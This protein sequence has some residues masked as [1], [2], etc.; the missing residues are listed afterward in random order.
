MPAAGLPGVG[1]AVLS[2]RLRQL[3]HHGL[4]PAAT[5]RRELHARFATTHESRGPYYFPDLLNA[6][7]I[8]EQSAI[9]AGEIRAG[10]LLYAGRRDSRG[11]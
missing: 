3:E 7:A 8:T 10:C 2:E 4:H 6:D 1:T 11:R 9:D 5:I